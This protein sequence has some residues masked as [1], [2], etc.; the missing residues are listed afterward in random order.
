MIEVVGISGSPEYDAALAIKQAFIRAW[1]DIEASPKED[2]FIKIASNVKLSG[3]KVSDVDVVVIARLRSKRYIVTN[4]V[5]HDTEGNRI[6][7]SQ[8]RVRSL[9]AAIEVKD[10]AADAMQIAAGGVMVRYAGRWKSATDQNEEQRYALLEY[11]KDTTNTNPWVYRCLILRGIDQLPKIRGRIHPAAGAVAGQFTIANF[12]VSMAAVNGIPK[13]GKEYVIR[14]ANDEGM[15]QIIDDALLR[16]LM[17][18]NLDRKR[19]DRIAARPVEA[20]E[21]AS[22]LGEHRVHLRGHGGTGKTILLLQ[23]AY[24]AYISEGKRCLILTYNTTL[25]A[26]IQRTLAL[27]NIPVDGDGGGITIRTVMSFMCSWI[28]RLGIADEETLDFSTYEKKCREAMAYIDQGAV[29]EAEIETIKS[30][31]FMQFDFDAVLIDE[32]QDWPQI[33]AD[34]LCRLY[35]GKKVSL[36]DGLSQLVR[37]NPTNW[38]LSVIGQPKVGQRHLQS[39]LRMKANLCVFANILAEEV[40]LPWRVDVNRDAPGGRVIVIEGSYSDATDLQKEMMASALEAGN[41]PLDLLHCVPPSGVINKD[42]RKVSKLGQ[43]FLNQ[44]WK[45]WEAVDEHTR[46]QF[47]RSTDEL[48]IVQYESCRGLEGWTAVLEGLDE[49]WELKCS[50]ALR[51]R[52]D[53][54][55]HDVSAE[56]IAWRWC[57]IPLTRPI[58]TL[59]ITC[60]AGG[61]VSTALRKVRDRVGDIFF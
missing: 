9:A 31:D 8:I 34:L 59:V 25:A 3:H 18:S 40:G 47:P 37:G 55:G 56:A 22:L 14:S 26:D 53:N 11:F 6:L 38:K 21:L 41:M 48:R 12:L 27:M 61:I 58:D 32:A 44:G 33:E 57:M 54:S 16:P 35:E 29:N 10:H 17:P 60:A 46:R 51:E 4:A 45:V 42:G 36:A 24:E 50:Q 5:I 20:K 23:T 15:E 7:G 28:S 43:A 49:F 1:P 19:M 39:G 30:S 13:I 2:D 52:Q